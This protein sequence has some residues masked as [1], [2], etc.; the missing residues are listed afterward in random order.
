MASQSFA[1]TVGKW[2]EAVPEALLAVF[3]ESAQEL[4]KQLTD[5]L[6][7]MVYEKPESSNYKRTQFLLSSLLASTTEMPLA[8]RKNPGV[9]VTPNFEQV[10]FVINNAELGETIFLGYSSEYG[11]FVHF[12]TSK[13]PPRPW[14]S[15]VS[16]RW[17]GIVAD[18][19]ADVKQRFGL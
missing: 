5:Q 4:A 7:S 14:V 2:A 19:A 1:A 3:R 9:T 16:Q 11:P 18:K 6:A 13:M 17:Q 8:N 10:E 12:G 15:M